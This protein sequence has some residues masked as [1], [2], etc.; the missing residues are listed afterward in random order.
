MHF[1]SMSDVMILRYWQ[2]VNIISDIVEPDYKYQ[3]F[4]V[5]GVP[6]ISVSQ[7]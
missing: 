2:I 4:A 5:W 3:I 1:A 6:R 7:D